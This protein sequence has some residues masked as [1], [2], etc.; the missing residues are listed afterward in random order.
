MTVIIVNRNLSLPHDV[1]VNLTN[2]QA[3][4]GS[5]KTLQLASLPAT[6]TFKTHTSNALK[7]NSVTVNSN[8][9]TI[10]VPAL[11]TTAVLLKSAI[12]ATNDLNH[13]SDEIR[14]YPSPAN[15]FIQIELVQNMEGPVQLA[16]YDLTGRKIK[17]I[18]MIAENYIPLTVDVYDI[19]PGVYILS[20]NSNQNT[21]TK[22][23]SITR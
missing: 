17:N 7:E 18:K 19:K 22:R 5:Y 1:T 2:F 10:S 14:I 9:F 23:F 13:Q 11:S 12:T 3:S 20:V 6:E 16:V 8:S 21:Y 15:D 4:D